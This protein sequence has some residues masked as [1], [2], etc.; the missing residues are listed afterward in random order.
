MEVYTVLNLVMAHRIELLGNVLPDQLSYLILDFLSVTECVTEW[1]VASQNYWNR[2]LR[3]MTFS[4][5]IY[6]N[7]IQSS[8]PYV[9]AIICYM[10][11]H[12]KVPP[13]QPESG[14][15]KLYAAVEIPVRSLFLLYAS[16]L[17][18]M[19]LL[20][21]EFKSH[22][23]AAI[24]LLQT[25]PVSFGVLHIGDLLAVECIRR[26][27]LDGLRVIVDLCTHIPY[28]QRWVLVA[29]QTMNVEGF[30]LLWSRCHPDNAFCQKV[31]RV[32]G[33]HHNEKS[34]LQIVATSGV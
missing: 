23:A 5:P 13:N 20:Q 32:L 26:Y 29:A 12:H 7:H 2:R 31:T 3:N 1:H 19:E 4:L 34:M 21:F 24:Y 33:D 28:I 14:L 27:C 30:A 17:L 9:D 22:P 11:A 16:L 25:Y 15:L 8:L 18:Q 10:L 6:Y